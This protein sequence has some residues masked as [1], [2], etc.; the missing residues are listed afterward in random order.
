MC[1]LY[2][3]ICDVVLGG[4]Q[5]RGSCAHLAQKAHKKPRTIMCPNFAFKPG[6][7]EPPV[8]AID[9][10]GSFPSSSPHVTTP[11]DIFVRRFRMADVT[12]RAR[13]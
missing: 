10:L 13:M 7:L 8:R 12:K 1:R 11:P 5:M 6:Y 3:G 4:K 9:S 2:L